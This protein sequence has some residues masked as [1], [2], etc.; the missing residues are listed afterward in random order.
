MFSLDKIL[1]ENVK[2]LK[3]YSSARNEY[4]GKEAVFLDANENPYDSSYN[5]YPDPLQVE[6]KKRI[7]EIKKIE[8]DKI[9]LGNGSDETID[10]LIRAFCEPRIDNIVSVEPSYGMYKVLADINNVKFN[11]VLLAGDFQLNADDILKATDNNTKLIFLCSPNN[12]TAV[13]FRTQDIVT[14]LNNFDGIVAVDE[15]YIDFSSKGSL[16]SI[17]DNYR[18]LVI[19]QT[20]SKAWGLAGIRL[21]MGYA[22]SEIINVL[23]SIKYPY[24]I[25][26]LTLETAVKQLSDSKSKKIWINRILK[27]RDKLARKLN[28]LPFV[29]KVYP[30]DA[31]FLLV[32]VDSA[33]KIYD[34]LVDKKIIVRDRSNIILCEGCLRITVGTEDE[35]TIL[36]DALKEYE[37]ILLK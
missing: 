25:S 12:P 30:S 13:C 29:I 21:G 5:R 17:L 24:N 15:A 31:N 4:T 37:K 3:P 10:L 23:N 35:N 7:S 16:L 36:L 33:K 22:D 26:S 32:K 28:D 14:I 20:F 9:F 1:R 34:Y 27:S 6:V 2:N 19:L 8:P 11:T 18:N